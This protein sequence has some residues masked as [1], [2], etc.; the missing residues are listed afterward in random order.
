[1]SASVATQFRV[2]SSYMSFYT[3][4]MCE[5]GDTTKTVAT[6]VGAFAGIKVLWRTIPLY[7]KV[8]VTDQDHRIIY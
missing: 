6:V 1:M 2:V 4:M 5:L 7:N 3:R 8:C